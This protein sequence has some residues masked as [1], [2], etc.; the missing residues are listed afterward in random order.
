MAVT[1]AAMPPAE[2]TRAP[3][4]TFG[5]AAAG[6]LFLLWL[7][8]GYALLLRALVPT[9]W[10]ASFWQAAL[11]VAAIVPLTAATIGFISAPKYLS[12]ASRRA[13][14]VL[15]TVAQMFEAF[16]PWLAW[17]TLL[18]L[19]GPSSW[20]AALCGGGGITIFSYLTGAMLLVLLRPRPGQVELTRLELPV[21]GL[22]AAFDGYQ[23]LHITDLHCGSLIP[24]RE[25][26]A[27]LAAGSELT[28]DMVAFTGDAAS[29]VGGL[30]AAAAALSLLRPR[31]AAF[32]VLGNHDTW[33]GPTL[34][35]ETLVE[36]G[37]RVLVNEH[38]AISRGGYSIYIAGVG[39]TA[40]S[41][42]DDLP[43]TL[44]GIPEG[45]IV[46]LLSHAPNIVLRPLAPRAALIL[47]GH[48]HGGQLV[49][50]LVGP[51]YV[52]SSLGR[53]YAAGLFG[54]PGGWLFINRGLGE[55]F[56]PVRLLC[57]PEIALVTLRAAPG[58]ALP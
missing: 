27:R 19:A 4:L 10:C 6:L 8:L 22:P 45:G 46:V 28:C 34:V 20:P 57:P 33:L 31:D 1:P 21:P 44:R 3:P 41:D 7:E 24:A 13:V 38:A 5:R 14:T 18:R 16:L 23:I 39:N 26:R 30:P 54:R 29:G 11:C 40:Y 2:P 47:A 51:L 32:A 55:M 52:P 17:S 36:H 48:T 25:V 43:V 15:W 37:L 49:L 58:A 42:R 9:G 12:G 53:R 35:R 56:P 50:P